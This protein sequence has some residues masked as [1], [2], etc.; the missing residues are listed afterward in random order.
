MRRLLAIIGFI[1]QVVRCENFRRRPAGGDE[2]EEIN[3][4]RARQGMPRAPFWM[5]AALE[6][7]PIAEELERLRD[8]LAEGVLEG[9]GSVKARNNQWK[10]ACHREL[11]SMLQGYCEHVINGGPDR[12]ENR[13]YSDAARKFRKGLDKSKQ[14]ALLAP[15]SMKRSYKRIVILLRLYDRFAGKVIAAQEAIGG[16]ASKF[17]PM[18]D[19]IKAAMLQNVP[20]SDPAV[21]K[22]IGEIQELITTEFEKITGSASE[23]HIPFSESNAVYFPRSGLPKLEGEGSLTAFVSAALAHVWNSQKEVA[24]RMRSRKA[25]PGRFFKLEPDY[26]GL[27]QTAL[28]DVY[29]VLLNCI[30]QY[31]YFLEKA[32][33]FEDFDEG[34]EEITRRF[35]EK[36]V[37]R[38]KDLQKL[39]LVGLCGDLTDCTLQLNAKDTNE[40][41]EQTLESFLH[42]FES[43]V[44]EIDF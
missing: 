32:V 22:I 29:I 39:E 3:V 25:L 27:D 41:I 18:L 8:D 11:K 6:C 7:K 38:L 36:Y 43:R 24:L 40:V 15:R 33:M 42:I 37:P 21:T 4:N 34:I 20:F 1:P 19:Q 9:S 2:R 14:A 16:Q 35:E 13:I 30:Y 26:I 44:T 23:L 5:Y 28:D 17:L 12:A 10:I 31:K